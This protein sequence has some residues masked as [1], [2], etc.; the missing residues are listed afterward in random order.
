MLNR[1]ISYLSGKHNE[2]AA[3]M[4]YR[5]I[6]AQARQPAFYDR[7]GVPD[8]LDGRFDMIVLHS[9]LVMRRLRRSGS[10][11]AKEL[12]QQLFDL[13]FADMDNSLREIGVGDLGVSKRVKVM[14]QAFF[15]RV[16]AYEAGLNAEDDRVL[17]EAL[18]RNL[19]GTSQPPAAGLVAVAAY[20]RMA[21]EQLAQQPDDSILA[22]NVDFLP[23]PT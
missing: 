7:H 8:S 13:Q 20:M 4:L 3:V 17:A 10:E 14:A 9:F 23:P 15:G 18:T 2:T 1:L 16:E 6:V 11:A 5:Q 19:Y 21:D 22:G 12:S